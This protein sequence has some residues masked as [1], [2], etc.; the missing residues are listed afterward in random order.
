MIHECCVDKNHQVQYNV[1]IR[2]GGYNNNNTIIKIIYWYSRAAL[3]A[4][5]EIYCL[6]KIYFTVNRQNPLQIV[7][8]HVFYLCDDL[9]ISW[10]K[11]II[12]LFTFF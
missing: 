7:V 3:S 8:I 10:Q 2:R 5:V 11:K 9:H 4:T 1:A 6:T 12:H